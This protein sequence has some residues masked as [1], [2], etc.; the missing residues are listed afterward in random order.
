MGEDSIVAVIDVGSTAIRLVIAEIHPDGEWK[1]LD[2]AS[3]PVNLG[4]DVFL[5]GNISRETMSQS[6]QILSSFVEALKGWKIS[7]ENVHVVATS[8]MREARNRDTFTDRVKLQMGFLINTIEGIEENRLTYIAV[9]HSLRDAHLRF[10]QLHSIIIEVGGGSTE[11]ML[12]KQG[13]IVAAH[14]MSIGTVRIEQQIK[15]IFGSTDYL[16]QFLTENIRAAGDIIDIEFKMKKI[17]N[18]IAV[19]GDTRLAAR[20]VGTKGGEHFWVIEKQSFDSFIKQ[21]KGLSVDDCVHK[22]QI[23]YNEA[24]GLTPAL[25]IYQS[26]MEKTSATRLIVPDVSIRE[27][28]LLSL[29]S[30]PD[31]KIQQEFNSQV[32]ASA[33][34]LGRK[35]YFDEAHARQVTKLALSLFDQL[36]EAHGLD[37]FSRLLL[38]VAALVHD[39]GTYVRFTGHHKHGQYIVANSDV[40]GL[41]WDDIR[42]VS[43]V[44][45]YHRKALPL[46]SHIEYI[47]LPRERRIVVSKLASILR[48]A[49]ALD[50]GH[51]QRIKK[52]EVE[53]KGDELLIHNS[54]TGDIS[55]ERYGLARKADMMEEVFGLKVVLL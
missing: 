34:S 55:I 32:I 20:I 54:H 18:F 28:L 41:H 16:N 8:A 31:P 7:R 51:M 38:E 9:R 37:R 47:S 39:I 27:G 43:N 11:I 36:Q 44:V 17:R 29:A 25:L 4:R 42:I 52:V 49:D 26:F 14:S 13:K 10:G 5:T 22:F 40:F 46:P 3:R 2:R 45:R 1:M 35:Y 33:V 15:S 12:L 24:E 21:L 50:K 19:G 53:I 6:F 48:V 23:P 30:E